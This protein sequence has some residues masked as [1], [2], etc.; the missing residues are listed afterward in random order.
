MTHAAG[1]TPDEA[2][3]T[4]AARAAGALFDLQSALIVFK[5]QST[6]DSQA[7]LV[8]VLG[9][10]AYVSGGYTALKGHQL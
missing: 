3:D 5:A 9:S 7:A 4:A 8:A 2:L 10:V 6:S 1:K